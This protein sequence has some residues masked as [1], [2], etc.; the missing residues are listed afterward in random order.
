[1]IIYS[2]KSMC[3]TNYNITLFSFIINGSYIIPIQKSYFLIEIKFRFL[4]QKG[5]LKNFGYRGDLKREYLQIVEG[6]KIQLITAV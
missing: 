2:E 4:W 1:M 6:L 5:G 3:N